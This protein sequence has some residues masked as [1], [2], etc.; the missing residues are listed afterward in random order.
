MANDQF[1]GRAKLTG[2]AKDYRI[3]PFHG[4][5]QGELAN[6]GLALTLRT[7]RAS[8]VI[9]RIENEAISGRQLS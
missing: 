9:V 4:Y 2:L 7:G 3:S 6:T 5:Q 8:Q 1:T